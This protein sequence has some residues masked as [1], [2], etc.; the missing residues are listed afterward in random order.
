MM[1]LSDHELQAMLREECPGGLVVRVP[2][3]CPVTPGDDIV[4]R[5]QGR[6]FE[7]EVIV[8]AKCQ[9]CWAIYLALGR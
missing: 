6:F 2:E 1:N 5:R 7:S 4:V 8:E 9:L 3:N